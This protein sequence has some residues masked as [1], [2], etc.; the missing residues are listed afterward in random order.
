MKEKCEFCNKEVGNPGALAN[1]IK[2]E[3]PSKYKEI[4]YR[5]LECENCGKTFFRKRSKINNSDKNFC[6]KE[7]VWEYNGTDGDYPE[8][9]DLISRRVKERDNHECQK[10]GRK[11]PMVQLQV[12]HIDGNKSNCDFDNL[13]TLCGSCHSKEEVVC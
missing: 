3:H 7:C 4:Y 5:K 10:C 6:S 2:S 11:P 13:I 8:G 1:H 9:W 12:H